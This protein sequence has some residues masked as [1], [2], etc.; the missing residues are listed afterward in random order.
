LGY[1]MSENHSNELLR[2]LQLALLGAL[3]NI[4]SVFSF[5]AWTHFQ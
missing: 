2:D 1:G 5:P 4:G 3:S